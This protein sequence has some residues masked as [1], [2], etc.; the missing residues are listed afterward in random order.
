MTSQFD[1]ENA[2]KPAGQEL[3]SV[4]IVTNRRGPGVMAPFSLLW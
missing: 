3:T 1:P 2:I 4:P